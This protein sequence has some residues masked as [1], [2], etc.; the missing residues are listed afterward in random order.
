VAVRRRGATGVAGDRV[1]A[2][3]CG[4]PSYCDDAEAAKRK[5]CLD[6]KK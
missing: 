3:Y 6:P 5:E 1:A 2:R 4:R